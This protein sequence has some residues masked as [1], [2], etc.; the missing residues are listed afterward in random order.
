MDGIQNKTIDRRNQIASDQGELVRKSK[1]K[2]CH[3]TCME[4][5]EDDP[6]LSSGANA[7][8]E[9]KEY[10]FFSDLCRVYYIHRISCSPTKITDPNVNVVFDVI[11]KDEKK[12]TL[13]KDEFM[14]REF[15]NWKIVNDVD[16][17]KKKEPILFY[18]TEDGQLITYFNVKPGAIQPKDQYGE[19]KEKIINEIHQKNAYLE[20]CRRKNQ[21][22]RTL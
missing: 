15:L 12:V 21:M 4:V 2:Q 5:D 1:D 8:T 7:T 3:Y 14:I 9:L 17:Y 11:S 10:E 16:Y 6:L 20:L 19:K 22:L 13:A 18:I